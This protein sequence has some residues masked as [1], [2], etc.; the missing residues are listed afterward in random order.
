MPT[1]DDQAGETEYPA[2]EAGPQ[3]DLM[4]MPL[5]PVPARQQ[6]DE[7]DE[8]DGRAD[9]DDSGRVDRGWP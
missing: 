1:E 9:T 3:P 8:P 6:R 4:I 5:Q 2:R 7:S